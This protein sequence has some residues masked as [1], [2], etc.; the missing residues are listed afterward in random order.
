MW[1]RVIAHVPDHFH[2][3]L[4]MIAQDTFL[5]K[6]DRYHLS[7]YW[8]PI[9]ATLWSKE[10]HPLWVPHFAILHI[11]FLYQKSPSLIDTILVDNRYQDKIRPFVESFKQDYKL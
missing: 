1:D 2:F 5:S 10:I 11:A 3:E 7:Q 8:E 6:D 4:V 9:L